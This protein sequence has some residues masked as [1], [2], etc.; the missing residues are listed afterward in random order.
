MRKRRLPA[1][2]RARKHYDRLSARLDEAIDRLDT[3]LLTD[4]AVDRAKELSELVR[5]YGKVLT[6]VLELEA[7]LEREADYA[8]PGKDVIDLDE[9][10]AE[11]TRRLAR[12]AE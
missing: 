2:E 4:C 10:R 9:A 5:Q 6:T 11:I 1:L 12:L 7:K 8:R 3:E